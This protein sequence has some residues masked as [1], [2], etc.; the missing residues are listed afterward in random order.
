MTL[1]TILYVQNDT[2]TFRMALVV[3]RTA[4][5]RRLLPFSL[6]IAPQQTCLGREKKQAAGEL[7][8]HSGLQDNRARAVPCAPHEQDVSTSLQFLGSAGPGKSCTF[9]QQRILVGNHLSLP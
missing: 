3:T 2:D 6:G 7:G 1:I 5:T 8:R 4:G 9:V